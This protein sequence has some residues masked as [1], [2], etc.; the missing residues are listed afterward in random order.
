MKTYNEVR[1]HKGK[2]ND[3]AI[4]DMHLERLDSNVWWLEIR[5]GKK[6]TTFHIRSKSKISVEMVENNLNTLEVS[7]NL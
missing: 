2:P 7:E 1:K 4:Y 5:K 3:I 6:R